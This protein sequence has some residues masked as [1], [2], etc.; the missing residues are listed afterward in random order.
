MSASALDLVLRNL[1]AWS[2]QVAV[3]ALAAAAVGRVA[4]I[5]R[6]ATRLA[7]GQALLALVLLLPLVQPWPAAAAAVDVTLGA[8]SPAAGSA[9]A[10][11]GP[12]VSSIP[13]APV[14]A[15][16]L[17]LGIATRLALLGLRLL[18]LRR[19]GRAARPLEPEPWLAS[20]RDDV[21]RFASF[22]LCLEPAT[23][24]TYGLRRPLVLLPRDFTEM[25]RERQESVALH[26]LLHARRGDWLALVAEEA[27]AAVLFFHPAVHWLVDRVRL[28]R[29]QLIDAE[30]V[31]R[32][33][34][35]E[36][37][38]ESLV[39]A[40]R[41]ASSIRAV[42]AAPFLRQSHLR[43]RVDLLLQEVSMSR[44]RAAV[45]VAAATLAV[46]LAVA[47]CASAVPLQ[48]T[49]AKA[50]AGKAPEARVN[51]SDDVTAPSEP[52]IVSKVNPVY[53]ADA[54]KDHVEGVCVL[55]LTIGKDGA[56][57]DT[58]L[59]G[60]AP[61][62]ERLDQLGLK[63]PAKWGSPAALE[64]DSRLADAAIDAVRQWRYK[65]I[66]KDGKPVEFKATV[67]V[68]FKLD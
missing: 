23:P 25:P 45:H 42:P 7:F 39:E 48:S 26:E 64:G 8:A 68:R 17:A 56:I 59:V 32:V 47:L 3:L 9:A 50:P 67:T 62:P 1:L 5:E 51:V 66:L 34:A 63:D 40:A 11:A 15:A 60:S 30:V 13:V 49:A 29:E 21:A 14:V 18:R 52:K 27:L 12:A 16:L 54:K 44:A 37:Y 19:I 36:A 20:L 4:P 24:A 2:V 35:R 28:A 58:R 53:P 38:L 41:A 43:E 61:T 33:G 31:R 55:G 10:N 22:A 46:L 6:P 65:P 57:K